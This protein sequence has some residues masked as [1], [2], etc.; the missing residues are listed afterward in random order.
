MKVLIVLTY[1]RPHI[2]GLTIYVERLARALA[3][4]GHQI[5]VLTSHYQQDLPL[6]EIIDGVT[7]M[8]HPVLFRL[9]KGSIMPGFLSHAWKL[10]SEHDI[11]S[12]HL[13]QAESGPLAF[14]GRVLTHK[15]VVLTYHCDLQLPVGLFNRLVDKMVYA[16]NWLAGQF[17]NRIIAYTQDYANHS[18]LLSQFKN[19]ITVIYPPV[20]IPAPDANAVNA[21]KQKYHTD[22]H[23]VVG[24][25]AR[26]AAEKGVDYLL[27]SVPLVREQIPNVK[28]LFA[29][30]YQNVIGENVW[31]RLQPQIQQYRE[32]LEFLVPSPRTRWATFLA[33]AMCLRFRASTRPNHSAW[34]KSKPCRADAP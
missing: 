26:F 6:R 22:G 12:V 31:Q 10:M 7:V 30:E 17:A 2:S 19:K 3:K 9:S 20:D 29:G 16:S 27:N 24:F 25:A 8:R 4:R 23:A 18:P 5:T 13:P 28:Y 32:H 11:V 15:P 14:I 34:F 33:R 21:L 1:Y